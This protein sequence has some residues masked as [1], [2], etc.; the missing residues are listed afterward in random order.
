MLELSIRKLI[1]ALNFKRIFNVLKVETSF[2]LSKLLRRNLCWGLP[3][4]F[5]IE[6]ASFCNLKCPLCAVGNQKLNRFQGLMPFELFERFVNEIG[7]YLIEILL[8]NQGEP[9][10]H[11]QLIEFIRL[12]KKKKIYTTVSTNGHFLTNTERVFDLIQSRLDVLIISLDGATAETYTKY[13][14]D[15]NFQ[16]VITGL[17]QI[18]SLKQKLN[19]RHPEIFLQFLVTQQNEAEIGDMQRLAI[20]IKADRLLFKTLQVE[21]IEEARSY[22]PENERFR[23]YIVSPDGLKLKRKSTFTCGRLWR[24]SVLLADGQI[25][26]CCFDKNAEYP[27]DR[28]DLKTQFKQ[29]WQAKNYEQLRNTILHKRTIGGLCD[30]CTEG[31]K[32]YYT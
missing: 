27:V 14:Q 30:N 25:V 21:T 23:R 28:L 15:G 16:Q 32:I 11:P 17:K 22:L 1:K 6:P 9:F 10:L 31:I 4:I 8:F 19:A 5:T 13:R 3:Y 24:S 18:Q 7:A 12:S 26:G 20:A 2:L 29:I